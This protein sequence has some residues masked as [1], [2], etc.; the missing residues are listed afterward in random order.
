LLFGKGKYQVTTEG[1]KVVLLVEGITSLAHTLR[2]ALQEEN[3]SCEVVLAHDRAGALDS[4]FGT[5]THAGRGNYMIP[6]VILLNLS[7]PDADGSEVLRELRTYER[8]KLL[9]I[10]AYSSS[11][12]KQEAN[13]IYTSGA[14][15]YITQREE[16][17]PFAK[18]LQRVVHYWC[19]FNEPPPVVA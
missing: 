10:V 8:T 15:S 11:E 17:E 14:N 16:V 2:N 5:G 4:L 18:V 1:K 13:S 6:S 7:L 12:Q 3:L 19:V 9:P